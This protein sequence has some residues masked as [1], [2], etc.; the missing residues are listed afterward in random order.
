MSLGLLRMFP[1][2]VD[3]V[4]VPG[5]I[6]SEAYI[7]ARMH[8]PALAASARRLRK[9]ACRSRSTL[10]RSRPHLVFHLPVGGGLTH[11]LVLLAGKAHCDGNE[12]VGA[13]RPKFV[14]PPI[15]R[16]T[17]FRLATK[18]VQL[19]DYFSVRGG[20]FLRHGPS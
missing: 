16:L 2:P 10:M 9:A 4:R 3:E 20:C 19:Q 6:A 18:L 8:Q 11:P 1:F 17:H 7:P 12:I 15:A 14:H 5:S 13:F